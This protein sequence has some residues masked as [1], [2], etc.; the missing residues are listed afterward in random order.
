MDDRKRIELRRRDEVDGDLTEAYMI[1]LGRGESLCPILEARRALVNWYNVRSVN[2]HTSPHLNWNP[3]ES[4]PDVTRS[5]VNRWG[6]SLWEGA[7]N[8][9][10]RLT[11]TT[12]PVRVVE[13]RGEVG[14]RCL[15]SV[16]KP[17]RLK[18]RLEELR[19]MTVSI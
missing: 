17:S 19:E 14:R 8:R 12:D 18:E 4:T 2:L 3:R 11:L 16:K 5:T 15:P 13:S 6:E 10:H 9:E 1:Y 7:N